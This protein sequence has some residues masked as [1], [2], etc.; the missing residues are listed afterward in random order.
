MNRSSTMNNCYPCVWKTMQKC[1]INGSARRL[2]V[3]GSSFHQEGRQWLRAV[4]WVGEGLQL[5]IVS[6]LP[7]GHPPPWFSAARHSCSFKHNTFTAYSQKK[8]PKHH[9]NN[10]NKQY[11]VKLTSAC[12]ILRSRKV[13]QTFFVSVC[14]GSQ[15]GPCR[16]GK[17]IYYN[18]F[19]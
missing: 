14:R 5:A 9:Q 1:K 19:S 6:D 11:T 17:T 10:N 13:F 8:T 12:L 7:Q 15:T 16:M 4:S 2:K 3:E 18:S